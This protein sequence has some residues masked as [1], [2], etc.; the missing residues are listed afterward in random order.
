TKH[1]ADAIDF[2]D[3]DELADD[4]E[5]EARAADDGE[6]E[7]EDDEDD[8]FAD[9]AAEAAVDEEPKEGA[10]PDQGDLFGGAIAD[11]AGLGSLE[12]DTFTEKKG[13]KDLEAT[14]KKAMEMELRARK[15]AIQELLE[16]KARHKTLVLLKFFYPTFKKNTILRMSDYFGPKPVKYAFQQPKRPARPLIPT[17]LTLELDVDHRRLF[18]GSA[19]HIAKQ[20]H[21]AAM[22]AL[23]APAPRVV[24]VAHETARTDPTPARKKRTEAFPNDLTLSVTDWD[25]DKIINADESIVSGEQSNEPP[26]KKIKLHSVNDWEDEEDM[27]FD[28]NLS[29]TNL[30]L[31]LDLNDPHLL[32]HSL[33]AAKTKDP[34]LF[35]RDKADTFAKAAIPSTDKHLAHKFDVSNDRAYELLKENYQKKIRATLGNLSLDHAVPALRLQSPY[36]QVRLDKKKMRHFHRPKFAVRPGTV[37]LFHR[38]RLRKRKKDK[39]RETKELFARTGDLTLGDNANVFLMEY[40]EEFPLLLS[41][42]G[43]G[44]KV[45]NYYRKTGADDTS[46]PKLPVGETHVLGNADRSP[47]WNF[48]FVEPGNVVPT[49]Y[50][51]MTRAPVFKQD[52][53]P[54]DF[55]LIRSLGCGSSQRY[56]L[57]N[58]P[59]LFAVGQTLPLV[60]IPSPHSRRVTTS[61]KHRLKMVVFRVLNQSEGNRLLVKDILTHFPDQNDMQNRQRLK[62][63]ME[64]QR[65]GV[66]QGYWKI[67]GT[68]NNNVPSEDEIRTLMTPEDVVLLEY[69]QVGQQRLEDSGYYSKVDLLSEEPK[70][71]EKEE[72]SLEEQLATWNTTRNFI[73]ATQ[74][75]AMLQLHGDGDPSRIGVAFSF[76]K[77]SMKGGFKSLE[78]ITE[79]P[80]TPKK[81]KK[82]KKERKER[83]EKKE[84]DDK[85]RL[86]GHSYNVA[87]QQ[88]A[89][90]EEI[91]RTWYSQQHSLSI[92]NEKELDEQYAQFPEVSD[93]EEEA[94]REEEE[95]TDQKILRISRRVKD[96]N[97]VI[98][99]VTETVRDPRII[100]AYVKRRKMLDEKKLAD[101]A[102]EDIK[103]TNDA[104]INEKQKKR[105]L[106]EIAK[107][108][109]AKA[110]AAKRSK[111]PE[112]PNKGIGKG[113]NT[114]RKCA[115][116][117]ATGHIKTNKSCP[118]Y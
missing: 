72:E 35:Q 43:M 49:L 71:K 60:E 13:P 103:P 45:I 67:K 19:P 58:I 36:Y 96:E 105:L 107:L 86:P 100:K 44:S 118:L 6:K 98:Q 68:D 75:K 70:E 41:K 111:K 56:Y 31:R 37:M 33:G 50:N 46:R 93:E 104:E 110:K 27:I 91:A 4:E 9:L 115:T 102:V 112:N 34:N 63:F 8:F 94:P 89:Y 57:R 108:E 53:L 74:G 32:F 87:S 29:L 64:Y 12:L 59:H 80:G 73:N 11:E 42:F 30:Q 15:Q 22:S 114:Q 65:A 69:M 116:C 10:V 82:E 3:E 23:S 14:D 81:E 20:L 24:T 97:G 117:G 38:L 66:D 88:K 48:G 2:E 39:G 21:Q 28:G 109:K 40:S 61:A 26:S 54:S 16:R 17:K 1:A 62:E 99:R 113:R 106:E 95:L 77:T 55:M 90:D 51:R 18:K 76:L 85:N 25:D 5:P 7:S 47:F 52:V 78:D 83:K 84:K 79:D 101:T 92:N